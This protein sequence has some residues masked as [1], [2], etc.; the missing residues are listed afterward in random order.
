MVASRGVKRPRICAG[1][2]PLELLSAAELARRLRIWYR[3]PIQ[4]SYQGAVLRGLCYTGATSAD[5]CGYR[6]HLQ[7]DCVYS[8]RRGSWWKLLGPRPMEANYNS[9]HPQM[10]PRRGALGGL[11]RA[12]AVRFVPRTR[13]LTGTNQLHQDFLAWLLSYWFLSR[14]LECLSY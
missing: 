8:C 6:I 14:G 5:W 10:D 2:T 4:T 7:D 9:R 13:S 12:T 1:S 3:P 11:F